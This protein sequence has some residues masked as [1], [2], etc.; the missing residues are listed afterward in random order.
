MLQSLEN[1]VLQTFQPAERAQVCEPA[2]H[3]QFEI[4]Q[5]TNLVKQ[6]EVL[7]TA[8]LNRKRLQAAQPRQHGE[9][10]QSD[11][12]KPECLQLHEAADGIKVFGVAFKEKLLERRKAL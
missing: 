10:G 9:V 1:E 3:P 12:A 4:P 6:A 11:R 5:L 7:G 2:N 8:E